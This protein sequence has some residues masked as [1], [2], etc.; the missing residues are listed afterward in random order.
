MKNK[1]LLLTLSIILLSAAIF[2]YLWTRGMFIAKPNNT[3][4]LT[5]LETYSDSDDVEKIEED[6]DGTD[7]ENVDAEMTQIEMELEASLDDL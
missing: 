5:Q 1:V 4:E 7:V 3:T 2:A 6:I